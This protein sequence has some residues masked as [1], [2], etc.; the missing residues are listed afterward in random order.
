RLQIN[1]VFTGNSTESFVY[2]VLRLNVLNTGH[3]MLRT[4][5]EI[6]QYLFE[7]KTTHKVAENSSTAH[8]RFRPSW[9][10]VS[11]LFEQSSSGKTDNVKP[12]D[13]GDCTADCSSS[14][15]FKLRELFS[16]QNPILRQGGLDDPSISRWRSATQDSRKLLF[17]VYTY[18]VP[19][20]YGTRRSPRV[21]VNHMFYLNPNWTILDKCAHWKINM[22]FTRDS[23]ESLVYDCAYPMSPKKG[24]TDRGC[25]RVGS[26]I[27]AKADKNKAT[28]VRNKSDYLQ[29][30][31][32]HLAE[33]PYRVIDNANVT[34]IVNRSKDEVGKYLRSATYH[35]G[36]A[37]GIDST[38]KVQIDHGL[39]AYQEIRKR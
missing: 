26:I 2:N 16:F 15:V 19:L 38:L 6:S 7:K 12:R 9:G 10:F 21:S 32:Q 18:P 35:L 22:V 13:I 36:K 29:K 27:I 28:T 24:Q 4:I 25:R 3:L 37:I 14:F 33:G 11:F 39:M 20:R 17:S 30:V 23:M 31:K 8:D 1:L 5:F 34:S